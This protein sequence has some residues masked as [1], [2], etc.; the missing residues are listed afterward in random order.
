[1]NTKNI[2]IGVLVAV[3]L[4]F[5]FLAFKAPTVIGIPTSV[6]VDGSSLGASKAPVVNVPAP[7]VNV[8]APKVSVNV[9][10][11][12]LGALTGPD[13]PYPYLC[14]GSVCTYSSR[15]AMRTATT[16]LCSLQAPT[17][18]STLVF[19]GFQITQ[20]TST[21]ATIDIGTSTNAFSTTTNLVTA[22]SIASGALGYAYWTP[23]GGSVD[24]AVMS[25]N[26]WVNV[27]TATAGLSGYTY[28]GTCEAQ[29]RVF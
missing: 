7:I 22:K 28:G 18:T 24:D 14:V 1:M 27:K 9:P 10:D 4:V 17:A 16:T 23:T 8:A 19:A 6:T 13:V 5:G 25:P 20:G 11:Q 29:F 15:M 12:K 26:T 2:T 3:A 21:G